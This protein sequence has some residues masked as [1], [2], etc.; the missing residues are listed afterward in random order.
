MTPLTVPEARAILI[1]DEALQLSYEA[2]LAA[3]QIFGIEEREAWVKL[4]ESA[5]D[6]I[7]AYER[8]PIVPTPYPGGNEP[9]L[10]IV[11]FLRAR[12]GVALQTLFVEVMASGDKKSK[13]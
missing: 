13:P 7:A 9:D 6:R 4:V 5:T 2:R 10:R 3:G 11:E 12:Q 1:A 8:P